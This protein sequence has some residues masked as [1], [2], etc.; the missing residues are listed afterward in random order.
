MPCSSG[1]VAASGW[2]EERCV[3]LLGRMGRL[4]LVSVTSERRDGSGCLVKDK[5]NWI[6]SSDGLKCTLY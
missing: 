5:D 1:R 4:R 2:Y 3:C 6:S